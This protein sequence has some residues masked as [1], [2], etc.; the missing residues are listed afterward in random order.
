MPASSC[1]GT[2]DNLQPGR[3]HTSKSYKRSVLLQDVAQR[4]MVAYLRSVFL[5]PCKAVFNVGALPVEDFAYSL[6]LSTIPRLRFLKQAPK[7]LPPRDPSGGPSGGSQ[8]PTRD[9]HKGLQGS[10]GAVAAAG[11]GAGP[12]GSGAKDAA[13]RETAPVGEALQRQADGAS[14]SGLSSDLS[15]HRESL[16]PVSGGPGN[17]KLPESTLRAAEAGQEAGQAASEDGSGDE[18]VVR[19]RRAADD[20][21]QPSGAGHPQEAVPQDDR[22]AQSVRCCVWMR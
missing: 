6:G 12:A 14:M 19:K 13:E 15:R 22:C 4:A 8:A 5:Q 11:A 1:L 18:F 21:A 20:G 7:Q 9:P 10:A 16:G 3:A 2:E 17:R